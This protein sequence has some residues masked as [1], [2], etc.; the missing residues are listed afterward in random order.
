[1]Q[2]QTSYPLPEFRIIQGVQFNSQNQKDFDPLEEK[3]LQTARKLI[4]NNSQFEMSLKNY[5]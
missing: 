4:E 3:S 5:Q 1:M 2:N